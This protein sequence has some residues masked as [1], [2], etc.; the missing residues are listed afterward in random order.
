[1]SN[2]LDAI[3]PFKGQHFGKPLGLILKTDRGW[4]EWMAKNAYNR[5]WRE[6]FAT[7]L[8]LPSLPTDTNSPT[9]QQ[10]A[11]PYPLSAYQQVIVDAYTNGDSIAIEARAGSGK[12]F[13]LR[14]LASMTTGCNVKIVAFNVHIAKELSEKL[15]DNWKNVTVQTIHAAAHRILSERLSCK[16]DVDDDNVKY[17]DIIKEM[18]KRPDDS[19]DR[20][21]ARVVR[22]LTQMARLTLTD[23]RDHD[24]MEKMAD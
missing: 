24:A 17:R 12:T 23:Y 13:M 18:I 21:L 16:L 15:K 22:E 14:H 1:M 20:E 9:Y 6:K 11:S 5:Q 4:V 7:A 19:Y 10:I 2:L 8:K 3:V